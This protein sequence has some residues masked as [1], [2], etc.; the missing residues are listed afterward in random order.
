MPRITYKKIII[1]QFEQF[2]I[3]ANLLELI[4]NSDDYWLENSEP[5]GLGLAQE[6][7][8]TE[9]EREPLIPLEIMEFCEIIYPVLPLIRY[10]APRDRLSRSYHFFTSQV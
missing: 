3:A 9:L 2:L 10:L 1:R 4:F 7:E 8:D 6:F 5:W